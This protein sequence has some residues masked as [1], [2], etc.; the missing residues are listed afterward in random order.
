MF[1]RID[2]N[3]KMRDIEKN[4]EL[5]AE[6]QDQLNINRDLQLIKESQAKE[7]LKRK[8]ELQK[9]FFKIDR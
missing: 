3:A 4:E 6:I 5:K 1:L 8:K 9:D 2:E 7:E